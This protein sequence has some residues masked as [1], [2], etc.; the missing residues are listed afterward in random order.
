[1]SLFLSHHPSTLYHHPPTASLLSFVRCSASS[2]SSFSAHNTC[3][4]ESLLYLFINFPQY[5][6]ASFN[7]FGK[8]SVYAVFICS[9]NSLFA[10]LAHPWW[11]HIRRCRLRTANLLNCVYLRNTL[12]RIQSTPWALK[13]YTPSHC[14]LPTTTHNNNFG[15]DSALIIAARCLCSPTWLNDGGRAR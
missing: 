8:S 9:P 5:M 14:P 6:C 12:T 4:C 3:V 2:S 1:M 15:D 7:S 13:I 11:V 10:S